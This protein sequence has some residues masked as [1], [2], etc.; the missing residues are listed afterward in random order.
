[1]KKLTTTVHLPEK[2]DISI[3]KLFSS[4]K[5]VGWYVR[6][7]MGKELASYLKTDWIESDNYLRR[8]GWFALINTKGPVF[9]VHETQRIVGGTKSWG[10]GVFLEVV[11]LACLDVGKVN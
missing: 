3:S 2:D 5:F 1:M 8:D 9:V 7:L 6:H 11:F 10:I 4:S